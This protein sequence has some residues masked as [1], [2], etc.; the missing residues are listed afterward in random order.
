MKGIQT[1]ESTTAYVREKSWD[2]GKLFKFPIFQ[3]VVVDVYRLILFKIL[4]TIKESK[5]N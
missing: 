4:L 2:G 3:V 1:S 5:L